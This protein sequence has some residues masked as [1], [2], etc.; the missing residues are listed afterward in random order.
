LNVGILGGSGYT[1]GELIRILVNHPEAEIKMVTSR[2]FSGE[3][4]HMIHP[5]LRGVTDLKFTNL[6]M[7]T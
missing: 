2:T 7:A 4:V 6:N 3:Y 5:N 1:G